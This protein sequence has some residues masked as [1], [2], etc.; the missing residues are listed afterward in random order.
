MQ[1]YLTAFF[2]EGLSLKFLLEKKVDKCVAEVRPEA[3]RK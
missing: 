3:E 1:D 2:L